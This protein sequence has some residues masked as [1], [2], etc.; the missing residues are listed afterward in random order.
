V[1]KGVPPYEACAGAPDPVHTEANHA[2]G[3]PRVRRTSSMT[4]TERVLRDFEALPPEAQREVIDFVSFLSARY[5]CS[6]KPRRHTALPL[7]AERFVGL[8]ADREDLQDS[9]T[10][11]RTLRRRE[12]GG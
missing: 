11:V 2:R 1:V 8:W 7:H 3:A 6:Q 12:W 5:G 9:T 10:W 4:T